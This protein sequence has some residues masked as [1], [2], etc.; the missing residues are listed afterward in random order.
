V[1]RLYPH[2]ASVKT[3]GIVVRIWGADEEQP[4]ILRLRLTLHTP[5][6]LGMT[7]L[8]ESIK[9]YIYPTLARPSDSRRWGTRRC[10]AAN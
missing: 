2:M 8:Y 6:L 3:S 5:N 1:I 9:N 10:Q 4:Q 7:K